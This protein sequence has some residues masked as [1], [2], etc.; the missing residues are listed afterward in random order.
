MP[1]ATSDLA[2]ELAPGLLDRFVRYARI[3]T[4][5]GRDRT[6]SPVDAGPARARR[7]CS[8]RSCARSA[9]TTPRWTTT[10]TSPRRCPATSTARRS[11]ASSRTSTRARTRRARRRRADRAPR[12]RRRR[13]RAPARRHRPRSGRACPSWAA[14][15]GHDIVTS[16]GDT[17]LGADDKAGVAEI[18]TAVAHLA[19]HPELPRPT[20]RVGFT[21]D[22]EIGEGASL[23]DIEALRRARAPTRSTARASASCRTRRSRPPRSTIAH[24]RA[25]TS[26][27]GFATGKLVNAGRARRAHPRGAAVR[28]ADAGDDRRAARASS[29][30]TR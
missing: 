1:P 29:T 27:P 25:S 7:A 20:L 24:R 17:L 15:A 3:D 8:S 28:P 9:S 4:Q 13:H 22:E 2:A 19:A 26:I 6:Q 18:M 12:L 11:S 23:F 5:A 10:A 14:R 30:P 21:P 16:S